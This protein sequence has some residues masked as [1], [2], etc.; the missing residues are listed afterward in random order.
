MVETI[1]TTDVLGGKVEQKILRLSNA[2]A[3]SFT[4]Q[5]VLDVLPALGLAKFDMVIFVPPS[6]KSKAYIQSTPK[7]SLH[8]RRF[9]VREKEMEL[10]N[11]EGAAK[12]NDGD[13]EICPKL[14]SD[15]KKSRPTP[16][17]GEYGYSVGDRVEVVWPATAYKNDDCINAFNPARSNE[18]CAKCCR[19]IQGVCLTELRLQNTKDGPPKP[20]Q[21][22][23]GGGEGGGDSETGKEEKQLEEKLQGILKNRKRDDIDRVFDELDENGDGVLSG[24]EFE[25]ALTKLAPEILQPGIAVGA[26]FGGKEKYYPGKIHA[27]NGDG[28]YEIECWTK[29]EM[30]EDEVCKY[31]RLV[32]VASDLR[33]DAMDLRVL[34]EI[35][36]GQVREIK[37]ARDLIKV[38]S[39]TSQLTPLEMSQLTTRFSRDKM[40]EVCLVKDFMAYV[41]LRLLGGDFFFWKDKSRENSH[42][43]NAC[44]QKIHPGAVAKTTRKSTVVKPTLAKG[45]QA[46]RET[47][48]RGGRGGGGGGGGRGGRRRRRKERKEKEKKGEKEEEEEEEEEEGEE[49]EKEEKEE[50]EKEEKEEEEKE[51]EEEGGGGMQDQTPKS[52]P[53]YSLPTRK[54][55]EDRKHDQSLYEFEPCAVPIP[56]DKPMKG[57]VLF[58][59][60][61]PVDQKPA[62]GIDFDEKNREAAGTSPAFRV[63]EANNKAEVDT[64]KEL[65]ALV[66]M[67]TKMAY[68]VSALVVLN[69]QDDCSFARA[70]GRAC[71]SV[72]LQTGMDRCPLHVLVIGNTCKLRKGE[73]LK[74]WKST[75][76]VSPQKQGIRD[77]LEAI[78]N[79]LKPRRKGGGY[80]RYMNPKQ[81]DRIVDVIPGATHLIMI[82]G[83]EKMTTDDESEY[84]KSLEKVPSDADDDSIVEEWRESPAQC[85]TFRS[86]FIQ[87]ISHVKSTLAIAMF[88][89]EFPEMADLVSRKVPLLLL[90]TRIRYTNRHE[91]LTVS[92]LVLKFRWRDETK[93]ACPL[94]TPSAA[95][96]Q[97]YVKEEVLCREQVEEALVEMAEIFNRTQDRL[98]ASGTYEAYRFGVLAFWHSALRSLPPF[99]SDQDKDEACLNKQNIG[100]ALKQLKNKVSMAVMTEQD[101]KGAPLIIFDCLC[102]GAKQRHRDTGQKP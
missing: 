100:G 61:S 24:S 74:K 16:L 75:K 45:S 102:A 78:E 71:R 70:L 79:G 6:T 64:E 30:D 83:A 72:Q 92:P 54:P 5:N 81:F 49:E 95:E 58:R 12:A 14:S 55:D 90:D 65:I 91:R 73:H 101:R 8:L 40:G 7:A 66:K 94:F 67:I 47:G 96:Q 18:W 88:D 52:S 69:G 13:V 32:H 3:A 68:E 29:K 51:E 84:E 1:E 99:L 23:G 36:E 22:G 53:Y 77:A 38:L 82:D 87:A 17:P 35:E 98:H 46:P 28:T 63:P 80:L 10:L 33:S 42:W 57:K 93:N 27:Y 25:R 44:K 62:Y 50:E 41:V 2:Q 86:T 43:C 11:D 85:D 39:E 56:V 97:R 76:A 15:S 9:Q 4:P 20:A 37:V 59:Y 26:R 19:R 21:G 31:L 48:G 60:K 89:G 34:N